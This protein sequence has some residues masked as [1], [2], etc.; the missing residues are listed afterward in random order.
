MT[1]DAIRRTATALVLA[2]LV[3]GGLAV[4]ATTAEAGTRAALL[5]R[6]WSG[7]GGG[8]GS[9]GGVGGGGLGGGGWFCRGGAFEEAEELDREGQ[10]QGR[11]LLGRDL[12]HGLQ[13][14]QLQRGRVV[15][16]DRRRLGQL[17]RRLELPVRGDDPRPPL[18]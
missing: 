7:G 4:C 6:G 18:P 16:H 5:R 9:G 13:Q 3:L 1:G 10:D 12:D 15:G 14:A 17:L 8:V 2:P 11:V